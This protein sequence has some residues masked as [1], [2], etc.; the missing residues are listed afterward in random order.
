MPIVWHPKRWLNFCMS[1]DKEK[2]VEPIL[3]E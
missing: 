3:T 2:E 1:E